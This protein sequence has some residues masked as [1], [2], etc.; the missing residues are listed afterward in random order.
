MR[1][2]VQSRRN[3]A[4]KIITLIDGERSLSGSPVL[5][6]GTGT[7][8]ISAELARGAGRAG[9]TVSIDTMDTRVDEDGYESSLL[10]GVTL[11]FG[12]ASFDVVVSNHVVEHVGGRR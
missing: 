9:H 11:P 1:F 5:E 7:D 3:K 12:D 8:V 4:Q 2:D 6:I 10:S